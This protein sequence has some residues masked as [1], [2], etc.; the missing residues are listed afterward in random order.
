MFP[1]LEH[2]SLVRK[3]SQELGVPFG[4]VS[5]RV[6][7]LRMHIRGSASLGSSLNSQNSGVPGAAA[8]TYSPSYRLSGEDGLSPGV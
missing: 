7:G 2:F 8:C 4:R 5:S 1:A 3:V 6:Q